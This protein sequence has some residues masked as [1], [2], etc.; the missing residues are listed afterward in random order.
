MKKTTLALTA[1]L[2]AICAVLSPSLGVSAAAADEAYEA[3][4]PEG[5]EVG[6]RFLEVL[7]GKRANTK[8]DSTNDSASPATLT[9]GGDV[10]GIRIKEN[11]ITVVDSRDCDDIKEGDKI[12]SIGGIEVKSISDVKSALSSLDGGDVT[13]KIK[14]REKISTV[15]VKPEIVG[16]EVRLGVSVRDGAAGI[17]TVTYYDEQRGVFG[18]L[19]HGI[20]DPDTSVPI[21]ISE[22]VVCGVILGGVQKG[23]EGKPGELCGVLTSDTYGTLYANTDLGVF[24]ELSPK[25]NGTNPEYP[26][27]VRGEVNEGEAKIIST[28]KNGKKAEYSV[29]IFD[30]NESSTG[31]KSFKIKVTDPALIALTGGIVRGM[32]G[33][34][35]IQNGKLVGAVT[36][37]MV[38]DPTEGY[39]IF[40]ENMLNASQAARNELP[41]AA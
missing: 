11:C 37:V 38:A 24:G 31:T 23:A 3:Y 26:I 15:T 22:G 18:G 10:F 12:I 35:I 36:H 20:C 28:V 19:G 14:R 17:G 32:S 2:L 1:L 25:E 41:R 27:A 6:S 7:F 13:L 34:P 9:A 5:C 21:E 8:K 4:L 40:I 30:V 16:D 39:G 29:R 33:S